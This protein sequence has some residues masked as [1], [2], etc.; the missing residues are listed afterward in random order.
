MK[1]PPDKKFNMRDFK[2]KKSEDGRRLVAMAGGQDLMMLPVKFPVE[3]LKDG[4]GFKIVAE[5]PPPKKDGDETERWTVI[6]ME[7]QSRPIEE[8]LAHLQA[9][10][11]V[12]AGTVQKILEHQDAFV[13]RCL[14]EENTDPQEEKE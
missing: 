7:S 3:R 5:M 8:V 14:R 6:A 13:T 12:I 10:S 11:S 9:L 2:L 1:Q 4:S